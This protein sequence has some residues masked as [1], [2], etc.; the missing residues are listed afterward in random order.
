ME[1]LVRADIFF[2][3]TTIAVVVFMVV[4]VVAGYY[5]VQILRNFRD[6]SEDV[7]KAVSTVS[8]DFETAHEKITSSSLFNFMFGKKWKA[9]KIKNTKQ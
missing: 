2:F 9:W 3:V 7:K 6:V 1:T 4:L 5:V 8:G